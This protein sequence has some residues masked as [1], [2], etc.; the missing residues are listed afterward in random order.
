LAARILRESPTSLEQRID[1]AFR[2]CLARPATRWEKERLVQ[3]YQQRRQMLGQNA[4]TIKTLFPAE[5]VEGI[6][7]AEAAAWVGLSR[8]LLNLDEFFTRE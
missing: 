1:Y 8:I 3:Y 7:P 2:L 4:E 5:G 6:D